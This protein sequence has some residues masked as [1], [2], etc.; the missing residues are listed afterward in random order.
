MK[1]LRKTYERRIAKATNESDIKALMIGISVDC[2]DYRLSWEEFMNL[3]ELVKA[4]GREL[5]V[6]W[7][8]KC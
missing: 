1:N 7:G 4:K 2:S 3:R 8:Q 6:V 5:K